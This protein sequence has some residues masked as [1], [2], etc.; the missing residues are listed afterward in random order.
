MVK[1]ISGE[2]KV[3]RIKNVNREK[4]V[5]GVRKVEGIKK[6]PYKRIGIGAKKIVK[7]DPIKKKSKKNSVEKKAI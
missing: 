6:L 1:K 3:N 5:N 7:K 2:K 4:K